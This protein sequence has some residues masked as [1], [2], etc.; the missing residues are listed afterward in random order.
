MYAKRCRLCDT[1]YGDMIRTHLSH[2]GDIYKSKFEN[3]LNNRW[4]RGEPDTVDSITSNMFCYA[5]FCY[6]YMNC[7]TGYIWCLSYHSGLL[8]CHQNNSIIHQ[9]LV[10]N[11]YEYRYEWMKLPR[12]ILANRPYRSTTAIY[13]TANKA[14][15]IAIYITANKALEID[16]ISQPIHQSISP[17]LA[18]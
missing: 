9:E 13:I 2:V 1:V 15:E 11:P 17:T 6:G 10:E 3:Q 4:W 14:L 7:S 8:H 18:K 16:N 12:K 5:W